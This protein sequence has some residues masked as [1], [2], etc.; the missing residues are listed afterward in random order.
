MAS[1]HRLTRGHAD[2][3]EA[4]PRPCEDQIKWQ[5]TPLGIC[6]GCNAVV[7]AGERLALSAG[8]LLQGACMTTDGTRPAV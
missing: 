7:Y 2:G 1:T 3:V 6:H 8:Y 4:P 5:R